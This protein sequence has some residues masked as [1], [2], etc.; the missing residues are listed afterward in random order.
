MS[1]KEFTL[2]SD[3]G[4]T[5][6]Q[7]TINLMRAFGNDVMETPDGEIVFIVDAIDTMPISESDLP[8]SITPSVFDGSWWI[9]L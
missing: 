3:T 4:I 6:S 5:V 1:D 9:P 8:Q 2:P 7:A